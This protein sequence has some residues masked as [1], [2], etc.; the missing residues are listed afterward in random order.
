MRGEAKIFLG[1]MTDQRHKKS[2]ECDEKCSIS[3]VHGRTAKYWTAG[4]VSPRAM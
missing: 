3:N 2:K 4:P 1:A